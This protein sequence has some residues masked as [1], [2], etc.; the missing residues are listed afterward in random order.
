LELAMN[1]MDELVK[2]AQMNEPLWIPSVSSPGSPVKETLNFKEYLRAFSPC[3]ELKPP[4]FVSEASRESGIV[5]VDSSAALVEAFMD[6]VL[7]V[8]LCPFIYFPL[9][10]C[11]NLYDCLNG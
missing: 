10:V 1:A 3:I 4:G 8:Q 5:L 9:P 11:F 7:L 6:E 2:M